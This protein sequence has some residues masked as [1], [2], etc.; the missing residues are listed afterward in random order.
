MTFKRLSSKDNLIPYKNV[1]SYS[2]IGEKFKKFAV[3]Y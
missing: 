2:E 3:E 1:G